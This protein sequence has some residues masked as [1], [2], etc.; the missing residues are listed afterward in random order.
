MPEIRDGDAFSFSL[1]G[2]TQPCLVY[3]ASLFERTSCPRDAKPLADPPKLNS[4][5]RV[6]MLGSVRADDD[7]GPARATVIATVTNLPDNSEPRDLHEFA[8]GMADGLVKS[9]P[10]A[11]LRSGPDAKLV[12]LGGVHAAR[13]VF[14]VDGLSAQGLDHVIS[15]ATWA[16]TNDYTVTFMANPAHGPAV[17]AMADRMA[18]TIHVAHPAPPRSLFRG[19]GISGTFVGALAALTVPAI[20][21]FVVAKRRKRVASP[22]GQT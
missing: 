9:K 14:D 13:I 4:D 19:R 5:S 8:R 6:L 17:D 15:Y 21:W 3:P 10:G 7:G 16:E 12:I 18:T 1:E 22:A 11:K 2:N 20:V